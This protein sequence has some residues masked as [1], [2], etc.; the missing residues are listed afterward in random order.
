MY[1]WSVTAHHGEAPDPRLLGW[2][3]H[4]LDQVINVG[5]WTVVVGVGLIVVMIPVAV[6]AIYLFQTRRYAGGMGKK[7]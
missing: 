6:A 5:P 1:L 7:T 4:L 3:K 2:I